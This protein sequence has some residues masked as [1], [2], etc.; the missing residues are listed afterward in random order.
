MNRT[1]VA[2]RA[3]VAAGVL[4]LATPMISHAQAAAPSPAPGATQTLSPVDSPRAFLG[5]DI[6][7]DYYLANYSQLVGYW[8]RLESQ[9][10][11]VK[12]IDI[13]RTVQ[14]RVQ[15]MAAVS[16][17]ENL[18]ALDRYRAL[19]AR[20]ASAKDADVEVAR[21]L[22]REGKAIV[23]IDG[24]IHAAESE[25]TQALFQQVYDLVSG[26]DPEAK[27]IRD[28]VIVLFS[29]DNPDGHEMI[30]DWYMRI[31]EPQ[32]REANFDSIP[33]M[34]HPYVGHDLNRDLYMMEMPETANMGRVLFHDWRPQI[35]LNQHQ[36][37]P[38]G[39]VVFIP[40]FRDPF[41]YHY[42][43]LV[44][45]QL[46]ALGASL[47]SRLI[48]NDMP[49]S[50]M[51]G[52]ATYD[53]WYNG[54]VR[55]SSYFHNALGV[56]TEIMGMPTPMKLPLVPDNQLPRN[57]L[58]APIAPQTW[59]MKRS[60]DYSVM[61]GRATFTYAARNREDLL[62]NIYK[63]GRNSIDKGQTDSWTASASR[64]AALKA[65][66]GGDGQKFADPTLY[67]KILRDPAHR[68]PRAYVI[69]ADQADLPTAVRF[70]NA[71]IKGGVEVQRAQSPFALGGKTYPAG[72]FVVETAQAYRP[73]ILDM[74]EPQDHP[75]NLQYPGGPPIPPA[76]SA[77]YT[78]AFQMGVA[79]DRS[80]EPVRGD[81]RPV[82]GLLTP[83]AGKILG[84]GGAGF[85]IDHRTN[86]S[87]T[88]TNRLLKAG[89]KVYWLKA[90]TT[91]D[92][93][94]LQP[95][96]I[97]TP[98][99]A[100]AK[101]IISKSV[102]DLGIDAYAVKT[103]PSGARL[104]LTAPRIALVDLYGGL[105]PTG[106]T[107]WIFEQFEFPYTVVF[108]Q[109]LDRGKLKRDFDIVLFTDSAIPNERS[110]GAGGMFRGR[111]D[112]PQ[113][114]AE[115]IPDRFHDH[116][117]TITDTSIDAVKAF[118]KDGGSVVALG[119][120]AVGLATAFDL[121]VSNPL[122]DPASPG[123]VLPRSKFYIPGSLLTATIDNKEPLA[124]GMPD[125][126]DLFYDSSPLFKI[127]AGAN[128]HSVAW[129]GD[130][131][132]HSGW[133][134]GQERIKGANAAL[135]VQDG[136]GKLF[137]FGPEVAIRGQSHAA[138]KLLFNALLYG[139]AR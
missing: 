106:W 117:G 14:G 38:Y 95:G 44:I 121:P 51:R 75:N 109:R 68:D 13:G 128:I 105:M 41:N 78:L 34:Y 28:N 7:E 125:K 92:G 46:E 134:L 96:A 73:H 48:A 130:K 113:P 101:T 127:D 31:K 16:S 47:H 82:E 111:F 98:N 104:A 100:Q 21:A 108:P 139:P 120:S 6:G 30:S 42:D 110:G 43:P 118:V 65:A 137:L 32:K 19:S 50:T 74:F 49:G 81:L 25:P 70:L 9:S 102:A 90:A 93:V 91:I 132:L 115:D 23:W 124:F 12:L 94:A 1:A 2:L 67:D 122:A 71:L 37:S 133:A 123:G 103:A 86:N 83:P 69:P 39:T 77:G 26:E 20:L 24:G 17:P 138:F 87:F 107:R 116:L 18:R 15:Y 53:T 97:W 60:I 55:T 56:L 99:T 66:N 3:L 89:Q 88:L 11:R 135:E 4:T 40:P 61:I 126:V 29:D 79:F 62:F 129:F 10:D 54:N 36:R 57:D 59:H 112:V 58:P 119:S 35:I 5:H 63:M 114:K 8:K 64:V 131:P 84:Q 76:D 22:A 33:E 85:V 52:T 72:S 136:A 27:A 80:L 45:T